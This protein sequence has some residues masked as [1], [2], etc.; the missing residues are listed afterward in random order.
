MGILIRWAINA[1][2]LYL[3]VVVGEALGLA[4][5][6]RSPLSSLVAVLVL[7]IVN[8]L[9]RPLASLLTLPLNCLTLGIFSLIINALLF[10]LVGSFQQ[11]G[12][13]VK[14]FW[15]ALYGSLVFS[16]LSAVANRY[17]RSRQEKE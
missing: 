4:I 16:F 12:L 9:I 15:A 8:A 3:T 5:T 10:W 14:S 7:G 17:V 13:V 6:L 11:T 2:A 1:L